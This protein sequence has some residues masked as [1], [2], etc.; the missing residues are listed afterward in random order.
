MRKFLKILAL[1]TFLII[2]NA[3]KEC[4]SLEEP[5][6]PLMVTYIVCCFFFF[7]R[8]KR[9]FQIFIAN[10]QCLLLH[11]LSSPSHTGYCSTIV[12]K[13]GLRRYIVNDHQIGTRPQTS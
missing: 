5:G 8:E 12:R 9:I 4:Q 6:W 13:Q 10:V 7:V 11:H 1:N 2:R 3:F